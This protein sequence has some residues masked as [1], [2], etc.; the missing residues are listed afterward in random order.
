MHTNI[1]SHLLSLAETLKADNDKA[2]LEFKWNAWAEV[3]GKPSGEHQSP[4]L[5]KEVEWGMWGLVPVTPEQWWTVPK[6]E[7]EDKA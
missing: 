4:P 2:D 6:E 1:A 3:Y 5:P 7:A